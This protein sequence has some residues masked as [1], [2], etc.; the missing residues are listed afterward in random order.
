MK[1]GRSR[2]L[3]LSIR[4]GI[5]QIVL[6]TEADHFCQLCTKFYPPSCC[7]GQF[8][9]HRKCGFRRNRSTT[10]HIYYISEI[11]ENKW[12]YSESR[13]EL[14]IDFRNVYHSFRRKLS[15]NNLFE[16]GIP[17][18][19]VKLIKMCVNETCSRIRVGKNVSDMF[20]FLKGLKKGNVLSLLL[21][22]FALE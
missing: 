21:F 17:L 14:F 11:L 18:K 19:L 1:S 15:Y 16:F 13:H 4:S 5:K 22:N 6:I 3:Y 9:I 8:H 10:D 20:P 2:S 7:Q 12:E